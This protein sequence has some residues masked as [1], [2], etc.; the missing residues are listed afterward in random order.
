M[1]S[2]MCIRDRAAH[3][4]GRCGGPGVG[5]VG[6]CFTGGFAL[7]MMVDQRMLAPVLTQPSLPLPF[8]KGSKRALGISKKDFRHMF[9]L[10]IFFSTLHIINF[11]Y[12]KR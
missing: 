12:E 6:M 4:H 7:G 5:A 9:I 10:T 2:E 8:G 1:G 11:F 3:E